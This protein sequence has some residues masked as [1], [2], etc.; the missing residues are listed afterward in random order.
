[1]DRGERELS[2]ATSGSSICVD[3]V[4]LRNGASDERVAI[5]TIEKARIVLVTR[6]RCPPCKAMLAW[7]KSEG[8]AF[9]EVNVSANPHVMSHFPS[10]LAVPLC[11]IRHGSE[12]EAHAIDVVG[13]DDNT[14]RLVQSHVRILKEDGHLNTPASVSIDPLALPLLD[15]V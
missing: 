10:S 8:I 12:A 7:M 15:D 6:D 4:F 2:C 14:K 13:F 9:L 11:R 1:M 5:D 3:D